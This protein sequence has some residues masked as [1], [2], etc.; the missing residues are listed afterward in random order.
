M[1]AENF[2]DYLK[3][4]AKLYQ[5]PYQELKNLATEYPYVANIHLL[6]VLKSKIE[7]D[8]KYPQ[9]LH[10][11]SARTFDRAQL[12]Q[13]IQKELTRLAELQTEPEEK[14]ELKGLEELQEQLLEWVVE[15][16]D[17]S[18]TEAVSRVAQIPDE[19][20]SI[21]P[22]SE[23]MEEVKTDSRTDP[24]LTVP[25]PKEPVSEPQTSSEATPYKP[26]AALLEDISAMVG[27]IAQLTVNQTAEKQIESKEV[28]LNPQGSPLPKASFS[29]W[30][31]REAGKKKD[32]LARL[33]KKIKAEPRT[34]DKPTAKKI[35]RRSIQDS[36]GLVSETL[37]KLLA[38]QGQHKKAIKMYERLSLLFPQ[39]S[40]YFAGIIENLKQKS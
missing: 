36:P 1:N 37:A 27:I 25:A 11:L 21:P 14:L 40:R 8:P 31:Q 3:Q 26:A 18:E 19:P 33:R 32:R 39:K 24:D 10:Q 35:A 28:I 20:P 17:Q 22:K 12:Q 15:P 9:Y 16:T 4:P 34:T 6:L 13:L 7:N 29:S 23:E 2:A 30:S 38:E 5:L